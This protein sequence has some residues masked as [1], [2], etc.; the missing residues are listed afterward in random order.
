MSH[1]PAEFPGRICR[2]D[3]GMSQRNLKGSRSP[4]REEV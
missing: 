2:D 3:T 1:T 4:G